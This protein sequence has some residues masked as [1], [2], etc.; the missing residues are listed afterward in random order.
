M[1]ARPLDDATARANEA[2]AVAVP[3]GDRWNE[4]YAAGTLAAA[5]A[6]RGELERAKELAESALAITR[7]IDQQWGAARGLMGL[8]DLAR[9][10]GRLDQARQ[11]YSEALDHSARDQRQAGDRPVPGWPRPDRGQPGDLD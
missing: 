5:A 11:H 10:T 8:G 4:G 9:L 2:L 7:E 3:A 1:H 6:L